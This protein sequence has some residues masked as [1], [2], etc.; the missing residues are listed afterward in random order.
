ML[1]FNKYLVK[2]TDRFDPA[3]FS[4]VTEEVVAINAQTGHLPV[5]FKAEIIV[6]YLKDHC[7]QNNWIKE[8]RGLT[9]LVISGSL[10]TGHIELLFESCRNNPGFRKD[11][12]SYLKEEFTAKTI[13]L[14]QR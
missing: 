12:E 14:E 6:T 3:G 8:N 9:E 2:N 10:F 13:S 11:L 5:L 1:P 4:S 7:L